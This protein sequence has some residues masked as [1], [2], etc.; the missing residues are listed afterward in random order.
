MDIH[1]SPTESMEMNESES[2][3]QSSHINDVQRSS[4]A[5]PGD[6]GS[7]VDRSSSRAS[8]YHHP[9]HRHSIVIDHHD[10]TIVIDHRDGSIRNN[11]LARSHCEP[12][13][14]ILDPNEGNIFDP[15][16]GNIFDPNEEFLL[17]DLNR[18]AFHRVSSNDLLY[19]EKKKRAK[20]LGSYLMGDILGEG[21]YSKVKEVLDTRTLQRRAV[22]IMQEKR[23]RKIPNGEQNV[24]R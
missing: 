10:G 19:E 7:S 2:L 17:D 9:L 18:I 12:I 15:N 24:Q 5:D 22:K 11:D 4:S 8:S 3:V 16:G 20:F 23:L 13:N 14:E 1:G 21:S 6:R